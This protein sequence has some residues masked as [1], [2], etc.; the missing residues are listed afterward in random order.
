MKLVA[1]TLNILYAVIG[2]LNV[3]VLPTEDFIA[4]GLCKHGP[5]RWHNAQTLDVT[6]FC[7][8]NHD[9]SNNSE[10]AFGTLQALARRSR[11][12]GTDE[13]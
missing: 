13:F 11:D 9:Y 12:A 7:P 4:H 1:L 5:E 10:N 3:K 6:S 2:A 8:N